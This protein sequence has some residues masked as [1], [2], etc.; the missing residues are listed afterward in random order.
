MFNVNHAGTVSPPHMPTLNRA[1][2]N[3]NSLTRTFEPPRYGHKCVT[4]YTVT[5]VGDAMA[6]TMFMIPNLD[7]CQTVYTYSLFALTANGNGNSVN[8]TSSVPDFSG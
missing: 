6:N 1:R 5:T 4:G 2:G 8:V 7:L 3:N